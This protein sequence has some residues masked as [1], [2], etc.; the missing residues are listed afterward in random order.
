MKKA[1]EYIWE[2]AVVVTCCF[3]VFLN[4][5]RFVHEGTWLHKIDMLEKNVEQ[6][7]Q[8]MAEQQ[9]C[10]DIMQSKVD[11]LWDVRR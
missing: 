11:I 4:V 5:L 7:E 3:S 1:F 8:A 10:L 6:L 2:C 9:Y